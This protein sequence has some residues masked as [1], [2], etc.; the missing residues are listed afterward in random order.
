MEG[1]D[2]F[3]TKLWY[4]LSFLG[5]HSPFMALNAHTLVFTWATLIL[6]FIGSCLCRWALRDEKSI[7]S[8]IIIS[9]IN[10]LKDL[11]NQSIDHFEYKYFAFITTLFIFI[12]VCNSLILIPHLEEPTKDLNTTFA[13]ALMAFFYIQKESIRHHGLF[14]YLKDFFKIPFTFD[15]TKN[16][17]PLDLIII[18]AK[19]IVNLAS[20]LF[21]LPLELIGR[22]AT[23][24]SLSFRLFGN[25]FG[26]S[27][28]SA[29]WQKLLT[30][31]VFLQFFGIF[32][33][34]NLIIALFFGL[35]EGFIQAFVFTILTLT[36]LSLALRSTHE[37]EEI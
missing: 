17:A 3:H 12:F 4:P 10:T 19:A 15:A 6:I 21:T 1:F 13:L 34:F 26:G 35:F 14:G 30:K 2:L 37:G 20:A 29:L 23:I 24:I 27:I 5:I 11:L 8:H 25:I 33:G 7:A 28:I 22:V 18:P 32:S 36:Y 31:S 9:G 16:L